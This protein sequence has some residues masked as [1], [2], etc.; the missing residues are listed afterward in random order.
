LS[1]QWREKLGVGPV[2]GWFARQISDPVLR[3]RFLQAI[4]LPAPER[5]PLRRPYTFW[6]L[7]SFPVL[8]LLFTVP[9][10]APWVRA[11][12]AQRSGPPSVDQTP[13]IWIVEKT[14]TFETYRNGLRIDNRYSTPNRPRSYLVFSATRP[15]DLWGHRRSVPA[16]IVFHSTEGLQLPFESGQPPALKRIGESLLTYVRLKRAYNFLDRPLWL[17]LPGGAGKQCGQ[18]R[19]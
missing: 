4:M 10:S 5:Y 11:P 2:V 19:R 17:C 15:D 12:D 1:N 13:E 18:P 3:L 8:L 14:A 16:G 6:F 7:V 9:A